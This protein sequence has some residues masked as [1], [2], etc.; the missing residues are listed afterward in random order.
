MQTTLRDQ[1]TIFTG[2]RRS[3]TATLLFDGLVAWYS[4]PLQHLSE[5]AE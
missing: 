4:G 2:L 5:R 1:E 3:A